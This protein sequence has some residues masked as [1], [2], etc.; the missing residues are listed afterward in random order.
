LLICAAYGVAAC[1]LYAAYGVAR[2]R[3]LLLGAAG[4]ASPLV[5]VQRSFLTLN[6][7]SL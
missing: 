1:L 2:W 7:T 6:C 4:A 5:A 3:S